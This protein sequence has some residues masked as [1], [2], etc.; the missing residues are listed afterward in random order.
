MSDFER[1]I[2]AAARAAVE[3]N[4]SR[5]T[6]WNLKAAIKQADKME[7]MFGRDL[8]MTARQENEYEKCNR[9]KT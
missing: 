3:A 2:I 4:F 5:S 7:E 6:R 1:V 8:Q 9:G